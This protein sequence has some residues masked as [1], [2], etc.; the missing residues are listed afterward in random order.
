[1]KRQNYPY[2]RFSKSQIQKSKKRL[3]NSI[4]KLLLMKE[5]ES[6]NLDS[7]FSSLIWKIEGYNQLFGY[8]EV[9]VDLLAIIQR[10]RTEASKADY[11]HD[12]Y[13]KAIL[14]ATSL[15]DKIS[16]DSNA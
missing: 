5:E 15:V 7:Y 3:Q 13:R 6:K 1:M 11:N 8:Q 16:G 4:F 9:F 14:D 10:A 2:D 12:L